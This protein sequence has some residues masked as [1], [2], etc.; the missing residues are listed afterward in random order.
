L[1]ETGLDSFRL[2]RFINEP[3]GR[4]IKILSVP[5]YAPYIAAVRDE[6][7]QSLLRQMAI[8]DDLLLL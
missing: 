1:T 5:E 7:Q 4:D 3:P 8:I 6:H 2:P